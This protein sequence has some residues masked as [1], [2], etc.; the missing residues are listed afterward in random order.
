MVKFSQNRSLA[1]EVSE[2]IS[3]V[4]WLLLLFVYYIKCIVLHVTT[5]EFQTI[6]SYLNLLL[7]LRSVYGIN[8]CRKVQLNLFKVSQEADTNYLYENILNGDTVC[9]KKLQ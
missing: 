5:V 3:V 8:C 4:E 6:V 9:K 7:G 1:L 2:N